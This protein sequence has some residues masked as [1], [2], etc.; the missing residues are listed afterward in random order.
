MKYLNKIIHRW[1]NL[2]NLLKKKT[3]DISKKVQPKA[4]K[5]LEILCIYL[6]SFSRQPEKVCNPLHD[7]GY[8]AA[9]SQEGA[10]WFFSGNSFSFRRT[11]GE[12]AEKCRLGKQEGKR[13]LVA[14][15]HILP[16]QASEVLSVRNQEKER[17]PSA[18]LCLTLRR[19]T[20]WHNLKAL[21]QNIC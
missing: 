6:A 8:G 20:S 7:Q 12:K 15:H 14:N 4:R 1:N 18:V 3:P 2:A 19:A 17:I 5:Q 9:V 11:Q 13:I 21:G 16:F 10:F